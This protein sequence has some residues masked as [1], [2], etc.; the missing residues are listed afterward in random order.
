MNRARPVGSFMVSENRTV[1]S[2]CR[3]AWEA[4]EERTTCDGR[5]QGDLARGMH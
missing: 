1:L 2:E 5:E 3:T 4:V